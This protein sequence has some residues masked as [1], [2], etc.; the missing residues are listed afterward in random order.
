MHPTALNFG[1][2]F[3]DLYCKDL[4]DAIVV[5]IGSQNVNGSLKDVCPPS[6][7]YIGVDFVT[8]HGVDIILE[9]PYKLPFDDESVDVVV[10][11]SCFEHSD[12]FWLLFLEILRILKPEG[13]FYLNAP[14]NGYFHKYPTDSWRFYPDSGKS[15][16]AW[17]ER[18]GFSPVLLESF[19]GT[20]AEGPEGKWN[21]F[22]AVFGK[23]EATARSRTT[24]MVDVATG[25]SN[26]YRYGGNETI[27]EK[28]KSQDME[29]LEAR[30]ERIIALK[31][32]VVEREGEVSRLSHTVAE[33]DG[34]I[35]GL[36]QAVVEQEGQIVASHNEIIRRDE[37]IDALNQSVAERDRIIHEAF[38][39]H[40]WRL[41]RP[42]RFFSCVVRRT[43][44]LSL[45]LKPAKLRF[46]YNLAKPQLLAVLRNP[47]RLKSKLH[48]FNSTWQSEGYKGVIQRLQQLGAFNLEINLSQQ[49]KSIAEFMQRLAFAPITPDSTDLVAATAARYRRD[50]HPVVLFITHSYGGGTEK[51][52]LELADA[53]SAN[54]ARVMFLRPSNG[55]NGCDVTLEAFNKSD[56]LNVGLSSKDI[57]LLAGVLNA[58]GVSKVHIHHTIGFG[59]SIEELVTSIGL[60]YD[61]TIHD[62]YAICPLIN[63]RIP[64]QG[65]CGSPTTVDCNS[66]LALEPVRA[67]GIEII[68]WRAKFASLLNGANNVYCPSC[69]AARRIVEHYPA[70]PVKM[71]PHED[72]N[73][74]LVRYATTAKKLRRIAI[75]GVLAAH[76]G[77]KL[78]EEALAVTEKNKLPI[79]FVLIGYPEV[80]LPDSKAL[81]QTGPYNDGE[82]LALI[83]KI[84]PD[85]ILFPALCPETYS[86]TLSAAILSGRPVV[87]AN[88]GSLPER[89]KGIANAF[90]YPFQFSGLELVDYLLA[91]QLSLPESQEESGRVVTHNNS[92]NSQIHQEDVGKGINKFYLLPEY[93]PINK[94]DVDI[95]AVTK[96]RPVIV[97]IPEMYHGSP[98]P[99]TYIRLLTPLMSTMFSA[100]FEV[101]FATLKSALSIS[102]HTVII[103]RVPCEHVSELSSILSHLHQT[104]AK[105]IYDIDDQLLDLPDTHPEATVYTN[106]QAVVRE[107]LSVA[108]LVWVS[109][110]PLAEAFNP[111]C[112]KIEV[113][114]NYLDLDL[115]EIKGSLSVQRTKTNKKFNILYMGSATHETDLSIVLSALDKLYSEGEEFELYLIGI[116]TNVPKYSW[117]KVIQP[118]KFAGNNNYPEFMRWL[119]SLNFF[120]LGIAPLEANNFNR[121]KSSVKFW[122][123]SSMGIPTLAS[124]VEAY[125]NIIVDGYNGFLTNN[126]TEDWHAK[127]KHAINSEERFA[128]VVMNAK[129]TL[130]KSYAQLSGA[131][132]RNKSV[133]DLLKETNQD[134]VNNEKKQQV[135]E[136][137]SRELIASTFLY[138]DGIEIGALHNPLTIHQCASVKYVDRMPNE[139]LYEHY[140]E[141]RSLPLVDVDIVDD[142]ELL[143]TIIDSSQDFVIANHFLEHSEDPIITLKNFL[144]VTKVGGVVYLAVP[145]M[146]K[147]FDCNRVETSL[148]HLIDDH[149]LGIETSRLK[150]YDEWVSLVEPHFG[151]T[152]D[153]IAFNNRLEEIMEQKYSIHFHCWSVNGFNDFLNYLKQ[154]YALP[155]DISL[156]VDRGDEYIT[157]LK[158]K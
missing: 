37:M 97:V 99:C 142:G 12:F 112:K 60:P 138:G 144:R 57:E 39:S 133:I 54:N 62:F 132:R 114:E 151:R 100:A 35:A 92:Q 148:A 109:T 45:K 105:L 143:N 135:I 21:D 66:C 61:V 13:L 83:E 147:T 120:D 80:E 131:E 75:L 156:F 64:S 56:N 6:L 153:E 155:F 73:L 71:V 69:D 11:S 22:V 119:R 116:S 33:R 63:L 89:V 14:S 48:T 36:N 42:L 31:Q 152:Y 118:P 78:I 32:V 53:L 128:N 104:G 157:I 115:F 65:Y 129:L 149:K 43:I 24:F 130:V 15:L 3:F 76:K 137:L 40:S 19:V 95:Q 107:L 94:N 81:T 58:F 49:E 86:Y 74:P 101:R 17:A 77:L 20:Q 7:K 9:D 16:V 84:D 50:N 127:L 41:T 85:A 34:Q 126:N 30:E 51:H 82:L 150:H 5:D 4:T 102:A 29:I 47:S 141:L 23:T 146:T 154:D 87:V 8:G 28:F 139:K 55:K 111:L 10:C 18:S 122:D 26:G 1:K 67:G 121:C 124:N 125:N 59:F 110:G 140:P 27:L 25:F 103:N 52:V 93:L 96:K 38:S 106:R 46:L 158:K 108:D 72:I 70:A 117:I 79:E 98:A 113:L 91:L 145:N 90:V 44:H 134:S 68:W 2:S 123:Y 88:I 136:P